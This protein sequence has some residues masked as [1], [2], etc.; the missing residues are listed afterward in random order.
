[1]LS[2]GKRIHSDG[3]IGRISV[4]R[5][6]GVSSVM[7][8]DAASCILRGSYDERGIDRPR[9]ARIQLRHKYVLV[10]LVRSSS[11]WEIGRRGGACDIGITTAIHSD[12]GG[13]VL[14]AADQA[15]QVRGIADYWVDEQ[16]RGPIVI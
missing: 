7:D 11:D 5:H 1:M 15:A 3:E 12:A 4:S 13:V 10:A 9:C 16:L 2:L 6:V 8:G 14:A